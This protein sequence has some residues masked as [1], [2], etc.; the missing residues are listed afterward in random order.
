[1]FSLPLEAVGELLSEFWTSGRRRISLHSDDF[2]CSYDPF[3]HYGSIACKTGGIGWRCVRKGDTHKLSVIF[4]DLLTIK[5]TKGAVEDVTLRLSLPEVRRGLYTLRRGILSTF[6]SYKV[7]VGVDALHEFTLPG[8]VFQLEQISELDFSSVRFA[9]IRDRARADVLI[10]QGLRACSMV[11]SLPRVNTDVCVHVAQQKDELAAQL[12][13]LCIRPGFSVGVKQWLNRTETEI[14][15]EWRRGVVSAAAK[16]AYANERKHWAAGG[17]Y[18]FKEGLN[19]FA[20]AYSDYSVV[21]GASGKI[22][23]CTNGKVGVRFG[24]LRAAPATISTV[25]DLTVNI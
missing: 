12:Q 6:P 14:R 5:K 22:W 9:L 15:G 7:G 23:K 11:L 2:A 16:F 20:S 25:W 17:T 21:V 8:G 19:A 18:A 10:A 1:M 3:R 4:N 13:I 24:N